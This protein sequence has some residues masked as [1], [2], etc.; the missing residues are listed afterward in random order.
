MATRVLRHA[1]LH[2]LTARQRD[3][4]IA[5]DA[6]RHVIGNPNIIAIPETIGQEIAARRLRHAHEQLVLAAYDDGAALSGRGY[7][8]GELLAD[9]VEVAVMVQMVRLD[10]GHERRRGR[11]V[12]ERL[13]GFVSFDHVIAPR[14]GMRVGTV[15]AHDAA[16]EKRRLDAHG[17]HDACD[18]RGRRRLAVRARDGNGIEPHAQPGEHLRTMPD[19]EPALFGS[20]ELGV[21]LEHG[22][23]DH[24]DVGAFPAVCARYVCGAMLA[25]NN[26]D[27][28]LFQLL[29]VAALLHVGAGHAHA[30]VVRHARD[31][32]HAHAADADEMNRLNRLNGFVHAIPCFRCIPPIIECAS[33]RHPIATQNASK[34]R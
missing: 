15:R 11:Q 21:V 33:A 19:G 17:V 3:R 12:L 13:V 24:D 2:D 27:A 23:G 34:I 31:A 8:R 22:R 5:P 6:M 25:G 29:G 14:A 20:H 10:I 32:A 30:L 16:D 7:E 9:L 18:H 4:K 1:R 28:C 26:T